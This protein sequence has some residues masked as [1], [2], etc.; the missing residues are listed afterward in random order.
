MLSDYPHLI[1]TECISFLPVVHIV[2][3]SFF[4]F[5]ITVLTLLKDVS[6][7]PSCAVREFLRKNAQC[8]INSDEHYKYWSP[9]GSL[10][11]VH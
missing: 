4:F 10:T 11:N 8:N 3:T 2:F 7:M 1:G 9:S 5:C 6:M